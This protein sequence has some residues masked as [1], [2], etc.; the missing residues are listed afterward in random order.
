GDRMVVN[1]RMGRSPVFM[2]GAKGLSRKDPVRHLAGQHKI[3]GPVDVL[4]VWPIARLMTSGQKRH[5]AKAF[6]RRLGCRA[7][8]ECTAFCLLGRQPSQGP[9]DASLHLQPFCRR[10]YRGQWLR[11]KAVHNLV[12]SHL[13]FGRLS[14]AQCNC[15]TQPEAQYWEAI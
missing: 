12:G 11:R 9:I 8:W 10:K 6:D 4:A 5:R 2:L 1:C 15:E 3:N 14:D 13:A 7:C